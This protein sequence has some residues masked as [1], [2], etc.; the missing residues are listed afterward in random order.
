VT[1]HCGSSIFDKIAPQMTKKTMFREKMMFDHPKTN[2]EKNDKQKNDKGN[3]L[4]KKDKTNDKDMT[5]T[6]T[7]EKERQRKSQL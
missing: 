6:M 2:G 5:T 1:F 3:E 4:G 7:T